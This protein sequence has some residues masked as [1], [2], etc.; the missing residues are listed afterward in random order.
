MSPKLIRLPI[1][2]VLV[3]LVAVVC[4][5]VKLNFPNDKDDDDQDDDDDDGHS[6]IQQ[7][8]WEPKQSIA[9]LEEVIDNK[10]SHNRRNFHDKDKQ[11]DFLA[12]MT[13]ANGGLREPNCPCCI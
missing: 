13:F 4:V 9:T 7:F 10:D 6:P 11:L 8:P 2:I 12:S 1:A 3:T 5:N